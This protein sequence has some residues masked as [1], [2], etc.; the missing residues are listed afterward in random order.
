MD[1]P[2]PSSDQSAQQVS[3]LLDRGR[4]AL[5]NTALRAALA[6]DP[7]HVELL[8][9]AARAEML[10]DDNRAA[11]G[12]L[13]Q[14]LQIEPGHLPA[15]LLLLWLLTEDG[16]LVEAE[17]L[18]LELLRE[19]PDWA[20]LY[21]AY[22]RVM[23][24][25]LKLGKARELCREGLRLDPDND[26]ALRTMALCD[27]VERPGSTEGEALRKLLAQNPNDQHVL[28]LV[29]VALSQAGR[30]REALRG[31]KELLRLQPN[32][33]QWLQNVRQLRFATHWSML[34]LWPLHR[35]GWAAS[36]ALWMGGIVA[37]RTLGRSDPGLANT[38][39]W[40]IVG[41]AAYSW[42]WPPL[43]RRLLNWR[44]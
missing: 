2:I 35:F 23:L 7:Q 27:L 43:L 36:V 14:V 19:R 25:A 5:A 42:L 3:E 15:R 24:R 38:L 8:F 20:D 44:D 10:A 17:V 9:Q 16:E 32:E 29:V 28:S 26:S 4:V 12:T 37:V 1:I 6:A 31:A 18:A 40:V 34:P 41:Y 39:S 21:A 30:S 22:G 33:P 11:R 13:G